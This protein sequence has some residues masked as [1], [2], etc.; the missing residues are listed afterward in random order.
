MFVMTEV[1][2]I[3]KPLTLSIH[4]VPSSRGMERTTG[5]EELI[6]AAGGFGR[7]QFINLIIMLS[8]KF[9]CGWSMFQVVLTI[10]GARTLFFSYGIRFFFFVLFCF[11]RFFWGGFFLLLFVCCFFF[12]GEGG[13]YCNAL[14][15]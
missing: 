11:V 2:S 8:G 7:F 14:S 6:N 9:F 1:V 4:S 5:L 10:L 12:W 15:Q 13:L 3:S